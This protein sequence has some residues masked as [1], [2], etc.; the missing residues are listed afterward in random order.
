MGFT[1]PCFIRKNTPKLRNK[2]EEL[3]YKQS[4]IIF[5][6]DKLCLATSVNNEYAKYTNITN[7]MFDSVNPHATWN[8]AG[9]IDCGTNEEL[10]LAIAA[11]RDDTDDY[12][13]FTDWNKRVKCPIYFPEG[14][15]NS[16]IDIDVNI[17]T[18]HKATVN[19]L[20]E[21]F[22]EKEDR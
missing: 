2:L 13:W 19:E 5:D 20:I 7:E 10:F 4:R 21:H 8:C 3:G 22:K 17:R 11:L 18:I 6:S 15:A 14:W 1:T 16:D 12:Q 9:K